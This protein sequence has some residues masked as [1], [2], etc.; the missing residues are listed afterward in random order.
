MRGRILVGQKRA[1]A[2]IVKI[3][4]PS[5]LNDAVKTSVKVLCKGG[6]GIKGISKQSEIGLDKAC[7]GPAAP[8]QFN[9]A[10]H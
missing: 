9:P 8:A 3:T 6:V 5:K 4:R 10:S 7:A 2:Q 1:T